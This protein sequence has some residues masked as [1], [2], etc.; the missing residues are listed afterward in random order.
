M[1][2]L[3][4]RLPVLSHAEVIEYVTALKD[5]DAPAHLVAV[6]AKELVPTVDPVLSV[7][8]VRRAGS[9]PTRRSWK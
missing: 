7:T 9:H 3:R 5:G 1:H 4:Q 2:T 8:T 6:A